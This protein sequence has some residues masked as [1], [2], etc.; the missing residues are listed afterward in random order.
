MEQ[1]CLVFTF[2]DT[3]GRDETSWCADLCIDLRPGI[4]P[5]LLAIHKSKIMLWAAKR[6]ATVGKCERRREGREIVGAESRACGPA[7]VLRQPQCSVVNAALC[8]WHL[9]TVVVARLGIFRKRNRGA[10][11]KVWISWTKVTNSRVGKRVK[12]KFGTTSRLAR[13]F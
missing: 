6:L 7:Q 11:N 5:I 8:W 1:L 12:V 4:A 10:D 2:V 9:S 3:S 13:P